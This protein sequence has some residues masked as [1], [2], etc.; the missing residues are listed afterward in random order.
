M[1]CMYGWSIRIKVRKVLV[2]GSRIGRLYGFF[3]KVEGRSVVGSFG[4]SYK[5]EEA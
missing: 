1:T 4:W 3:D 5:L 2:S